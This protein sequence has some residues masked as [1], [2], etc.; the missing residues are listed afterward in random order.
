MS[1]ID[2]NDTSFSF[3]PLFFFFPL[4]SY[5]IKKITIVRDRNIYIYMA[6][7]L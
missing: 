7:E 4:H 2:S 1:I 5:N 3:L 6:E